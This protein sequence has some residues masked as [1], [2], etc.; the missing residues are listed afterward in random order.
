MNLTNGLARYQQTT[1]YPEARR[2][3]GDARRLIATI[4]AAGPH[5]SAPDLAQA[6]DFLIAVESWKAGCLDDRAV[7][8]ATNADPAIW[9]ALAGAVAATTDI[10]K[11]LAIMTLRGFGSA[12]SPKSGERP[13]KVATAVLRFLY[14]ELWGV[15]DWRAAA[16]VGSLERHGWQVEPAMTQA[17]MHRASDLRCD[18]ETINEIAA[19]DYER[20]YRSLSAQYATLPRAADVDMAIFGVSLEVWPMG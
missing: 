11:L 20:Q 2:L 16:M 7:Y 19:L 12:P 8:A 10:D 15:V 17:R 9:T 4:R 6:R 5:P 14:P 3:E 1:F 18:F 13:A